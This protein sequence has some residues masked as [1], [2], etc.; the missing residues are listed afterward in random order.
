KRYVGT[1]DFKELHQLLA[2]LLK[3]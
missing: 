1:P 3:A 2:Q